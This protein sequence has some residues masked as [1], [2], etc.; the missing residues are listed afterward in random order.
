M[1]KECSTSESSKVSYK[2]LAFLGIAFSLTDVNLDWFRWKL[3]VVFIPDH[4]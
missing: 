3:S 1:N 4:S 2:M